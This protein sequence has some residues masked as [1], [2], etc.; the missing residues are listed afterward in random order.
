MMRVVNVLA[1]QCKTEKCLFLLLLVLGEKKK[2]NRGNFW[3]NKIPAG[4]SLQLVPII[5]R[6]CNSITNLQYS[7]TPLHLSSSAMQKKQNLINKNK[8]N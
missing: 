1:E 6:A 3:N 7:I 2:C 5:P 8:K 4:A